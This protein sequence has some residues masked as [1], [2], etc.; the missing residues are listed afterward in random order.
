MFAWRK[1]RPQHDEPLVPHGLIWQATEDPMPAKAERTDPGVVQETNSPNSVPLRRVPPPSDQ[2]KT[3][4][5]SPPKMGPVSDLLP[6][7][8]MNAKGAVKRPPPSLDRDAGLKMPQ[9]ASR[10]GD[11]K[12]V[13]PAAVKPQ[14]AA[15]P[16][17][18]AGSNQRSTRQIIVKEFFG[19]RKQELRAAWFE[20]THATAELYA[21]ARHAY[22]GWEIQKNLR[23][24]RERAQARLAEAV[25]QKSTPVDVPENETSSN[26]PATLMVVRTAAARIQN[27]AAASFANSAGSV[28]GIMHRQVRIRI[29]GGAQLH[30][31]VSRFH[32]AQR[33]SVSVL[34]QNSRLATSLAMAAL[35]ALLM[36]GLILVIGHSQPSASADAAAVTS[37]QSQGAPAAPA[38]PATVKPLVGAAPISAH[39]AKS[40]P[41]VNT[42]LRTPGNTPA[43]KTI[44]RPHRNEDT[45][46]VA[47][48]T[49]VYY[50]NKR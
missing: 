39:P 24:T 12:S 36:L 21:N 29:A 5:D 9:A 30:S 25:A 49:Y 40:S 1:P 6:W 4:D 10:A 32:N 15:V 33:K 42:A 43:V 38:N 34:R 16:T 31:Y 41:V 44:H 17:R 13:S 27:K 47:P 7:A 45:D 3:S 37:R 46:Y 11:S 19:E 22:A 8:S 23:Q 14:L 20:L 28:R 18:S 50:G 2:P 35:S 26:T 48:D